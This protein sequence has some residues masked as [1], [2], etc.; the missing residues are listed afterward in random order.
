MTVRRHAPWPGRL[1]GLLILL[2][3]LWTA[4]ALRAAP[5]LGQPAPEIQLPGLTGELSLAA[6]RG[7]VVLVDFWASWCAPCAQSFPWLNELQQKYQAQGFRVLAVNVDKQRKKAD[8]FLA[9]HPARFPVALDPAGTAAGR[10]ELPGM[11]SSYLVDRAGVLRRLHTGF[12][13]EETQELEAFIRTLLA[14]P[15]PVV[16][17][18]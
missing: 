10:Y 8:A 4:P 13:P 5:V 2:F 14:E 9:Q 7:Q 17:E 15:A 18:N 6:L 11:P 3:V 12:R 16:G 1:R